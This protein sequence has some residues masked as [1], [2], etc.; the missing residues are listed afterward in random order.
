MIRVRPRTDAA[1]ATLPGNAHITFRDRQR[2]TP[3]ITQDIQADAAIRV[4]VWV[5]DAGG[6]VDF[7]RFEWIVGWEVDGKE[8]DTARVWTLT[9]TLCV[10][11]WLHLLSD[12]AWGI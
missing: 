6:E 10:S 2:W 12:F 4:D 11:R 5:I 8:E 1:I 9:L 7:R 3:L